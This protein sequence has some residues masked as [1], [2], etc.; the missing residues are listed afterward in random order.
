MVLIMIG[1]K[2]AKKYQ[3]LINFRTT[4]RAFITINSDSNNKNDT[5]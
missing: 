4:L 1:T 3:L 2:A 5:S